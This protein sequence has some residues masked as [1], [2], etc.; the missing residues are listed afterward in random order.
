[1]FLSTLFRRLE[2]LP[3]K[4]AVLREAVRQ[5]QD[6]LGAESSLLHTT[7]FSRL[8]SSEIHF[9]YDQRS[10]FCHIRVSEYLLEFRH[11][12]SPVLSDSDKEGLE[13]FAQLLQELLENPELSPDLFSLEEE[14]QDLI[15]T[16]LH[17]LGSLSADGK[18]QRI[19]QR[20]PT[21][22]IGAPIWEADW[23]SEE[24]R[25]AVR[26]AVKKANDDKVAQAVM[27]KTARDSSYQLLL[28]PLLN[29]KG[30]VSSL[31]TRGRD[32]SDRERMRDV[33]LDEREFLHT[34]LESMDEALI[35][36]D[37]DGRITLI[38][39]AASRRF[40]LD[41][42]E[43]VQDKIT[44]WTEDCER[45]QPFNETPFGRVLNGEQLRDVRCNCYDLDGDLRMMTASGCGLVSA[46]GESYGVVLALSD[47]TQQLR[48]ERALVDSERQLRA[49][50]NFQPNAILSLNPQGTILRCN[51]AVE[52]LLGYQ[53]KDLIGR[54]IEPLMQKALGE[55]LNFQGER[56]V[57]FK[58]MDGDKAWGLVT[59]VSVSD[60][61]GDLGIMWTV[62][63]ITER[64]KTE[65]ALDISNRRLATGREMERMRLAR[66]LHDGA[67][68]NLLAV[69]YRMQDHQL[70]SEV[71][72]VVRQLRSLISDLRPPGLREFGLPAALEGH[73]AKMARQLGEGAPEIDLLC[74][75]CD[76][77]AEN[78][79][80]CLFRIVQESVN[81]IFKHAE[82]NNV[83]IELS[84]SAHEV[85]LR[86][87]DDGV[88][89]E[90]PV[91]ISSF[92]GEARYGLAGM[93]ERA[94]LLGGKFGI[95]SVPGKG[96]E[97]F[98]RI[99]L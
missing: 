68:Q 80:L 66:E 57:E 94:E 75:G 7:G 48:A 96:T 5:L 20:Q 90:R 40:A 3:R 17:L 10:W 41:K 50:F 44:F 37:L 99:P 92:T 30:E 86:V 83:I 82:A 81:N 46:D 9:G 88:G 27:I 14:V 38:N 6:W 31:I 24:S 69:S 55:R 42:G 63:D 4:D 93:Q 78:V 91:R 61:E 52:T 71:V 28:T 35:V 89:F 95:T 39:E 34:V 33:L 59:T 74:F 32:T 11:A 87:R 77:L 21:A 2:G 53:P 19:N 8:S 29:E 49:L 67:V 43:R 62:R 26:D 45:V 1:M 36:C 72:D 73:L 18:I 12:K 84:R 51:P 79:S 15:D 70:R 13:K 65:L 98:A 97:V 47:S 64:K 60:S 16:S 56:E 22:K 54:P 58:R 76:D 85:Y 25:D 23:L